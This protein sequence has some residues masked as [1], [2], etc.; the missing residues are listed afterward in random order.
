[1]AGRRFFGHENQFRFAGLDC[2]SYL[3]IK[4]EATQQAKKPNKIVPIFTKHTLHIIK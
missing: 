2:A 4:E 3:F 1:M